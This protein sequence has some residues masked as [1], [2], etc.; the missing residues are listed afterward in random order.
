ML[1]TINTSKKYG[2]EPFLN[3][4]NNLKVTLIDFWAWAH[5][6]LI[7]NAERGI[8]AEYIVGMALDVNHE[9]RTEWNSYDILSNDGIK[10]EVK[11]SGYIQTWVQKTYS[12]I[13][14]GIQ[15]TQA[16]DKPSNTY[17]NIKRRQSDVYVFCIHKHKDQTTI[18]PLDLQQWEFYVLNSKVLNEKVPLQKSISLSRIKELGAVL[19]DFK[20]LNEVVRSQYNK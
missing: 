5:S 7:G 3:E 10:V 19:S 2:N 15:P 13:K 9:T 8:L 4:N 14:F 20:S 18:N 6:D 16:W 12:N 1:E 17:E 11:S